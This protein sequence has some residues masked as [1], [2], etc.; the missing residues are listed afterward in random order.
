MSNPQPQKPDPPDQSLTITRIVVDGLKGRA[1][2]V[3]S[4][5]ALN[6]EDPIKFNNAC[7]EAEMDTEDN[8]SPDERVW[9][10]AKYLMKHENPDLVTLVHGFSNNDETVYRRFTNGL[11]YIAE[12]DAANNREDVVYIGFQWPAETVGEGPKSILGGIP[13]SMGV[14]GVLLLIGAF[15]LKWGLV[16]VAKHLARPYSVWPLSWA[17]VLAC[18]LGAVV[19]GLNMLV[20][21][22]VM[23][24]IVYYRDA[25]RARNYGVPDLLE[26]YRNLHV[27]LKKLR[28]ETPKPKEYWEAR[29]IN[30]SFI[31]HSMGAMVV[32]ELIRIIT[33]VWDDA[34][35]YPL[36]PPLPPDA[37]AAESK[38]RVKNVEDYSEKKKED[39]DPHI[40]DDW[41]RLSRL[42]LVSPDISAEALLL[43]SSNFLRV[44][45]RRFDEAYLFSNEGDTMLRLFSTIGN[46]ISFPTS[47]KA[48]GLR[49]G[50]VEIIEGKQ[51]GDIRYGMVNTDANTLRGMPAFFRC[52]RLCSK[53]LEELNKQGIRQPAGQE[54]NDPMA[55]AKQ[56]EMQRA[57]TAQQ[58]ELETYN[59]SFFEMTDYIDECGESILTYAWKKAKLSW[60]DNFILMGA[61]FFSTF[62]LR[63]GRDGHSGYFNS[64]FSSQLIYTAA[65]C[66]FG[67]IKG[68]ML[69][70]CKARQVRV[71][72]APEQYKEFIARQAEGAGGAGGAGRRFLSICRRGIRHPVFVEAHQAAPLYDCRHANRNRGRRLPG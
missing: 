37:P 11:E 68:K 24:R 1:Y 7:V 66:G 48:R 14:G 56:A 62:K 54:R 45:L 20:T 4:T 13:V 65:S 27:Q 53:T 59:F 47:T 50:N 30:T 33:N 42:V 18:L 63:C 34:F 25:F 67:G 32:T 3:A 51:P 40:I 60:L 23:R 36:R 41:F 72:L 49:L 39:P 64:E 28:H 19:L 2:F 71:L 57:Q 44:A 12:A 43:R 46:Y 70:K 9:E 22:L 38:D 31:A 29:R 21:L 35:I 55:L 26:F 8:V 10:I 15:P 69:D 58:K 61:Y 16:T 5:A 52:L 6:V 17:W